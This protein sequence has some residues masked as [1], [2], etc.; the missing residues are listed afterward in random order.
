MQ[1][2]A[3]SDKGAVH[4]ALH[5]YELARRHGIRP[6]IGCEIKDGDTDD[7]LL[8]LAATNRGFR[9][10]IESLNGGTLLSPVSHGNVIS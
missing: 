7:T 4:G 6:I 10:I 3:V 8:V 5:F 9:S 2:L 1:E